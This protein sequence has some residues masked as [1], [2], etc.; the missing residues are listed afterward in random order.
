MR[1]K[2][3]VISNKKCNMSIG[4][5]PATVPIGDLVGELESSVEAFYYLLKPAIFSRNRVIVGEADN[6]DEVEIKSMKHKLL[7]S[8]LVG[9]IAVSGKFEGFAG[10]LL[11]LG[12]GH[13]HSQNAGTYITS[14]GYLV[15]EDGLLNGIHDEP[16]IVTDTFDF[17]IGFVGSQVGGGL[18][19]VIINER[20]DKSRSS[21]SVI[22]DHDMRDFNL[23]YFPESSG[24]SP[25]RKTQVD[26]VSETKP[27]DVS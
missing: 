14:V 17:R 20:L 6:L 2:E 4:A 23:M 26:V 11:E 9:I 19:V 18:V 27:H 13:A 22:A 25:S 12:K 24:S 8:K 7:L 16:D 1:S 10:E 5:F 3:I 15:S 21:F